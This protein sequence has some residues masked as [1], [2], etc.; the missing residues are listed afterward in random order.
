MYTYIDTKGKLLK[1]IPE[2]IKDDT[3]SID[4]ESSDLNP[5]TATLLLIQIESN[6]INYI[7]DVRK[8]GK[9]TISYLFSLIKDSNKLCIGHNIKFDCKMIYHNTGELIHNVYDTMLGEVLINQG[10]GEQFYNLPEVV[11]KY[12]GVTI[13]K[14]VRNT[15]IG[16]T[17]EITEEQLIYSAIDIQYLKPIRTAQLELL[18]NQLQ[19]VELEMKFLPVACKMEYDGVLLDKDLWTAAYSKYYELIKVPESEIKKQI[20][21]SIEPGKFETALQVANFLEIPVK[22]KKLSDTLSSMKAE[23]C[24]SWLL[25]NLNINSSKQMKTA[26]NNMGIAVEDTNEKTLRRFM[27]SPIISTILTY[28]EYKKKLT[29][30]GETILKFISPVTGR[31]HTEYNQLGTQTGRLSSD[32]PNLQNIPRDEDYRN[33]FVPRPGYTFVTADYSQAELRLLAAI[34]REQVMIDAFLNEIDLHTLTASVIKNKPLNEIT[35][36]DRHDGKTVNFAIVYGTSAYGMYYN[37]GVPVE[38]AEDYINKFFD[39][40]KT[41]KKFIDMVGD[42]IWEKKYST[43]PYGRRRLFQEKPIYQDSYEY[44]RHIKRVKREGVNHIIQGCCADIMKM[45]MIDIESKNPFGEEFRM[46]L[47]VHDEIVVEVRDDLV[48]EAEK[49]MQDIMLEKEQLFLGVVPA[50]VDVT[51]KKYW[52]KG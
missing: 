20:V 48:E 32:S 25:D 35:K 31:V 21:D 33:S 24:K 46:V 15:F 18:K 47:Q 5:Y 27:S 9:E 7:L 40:Y 39:G 28:R 4:V 43:T 6:Q 44:D 22:T 14:E 50:K 1:L 19:V 10:I 3:L 17:G 12:T 23:F 42:R 36:P 52:S 16:Y 30:Y 51:V 11:L 13:S 45:A 38:L 49:F 8:I 29:T 26:L 37:S 2:I 41:L 34:S